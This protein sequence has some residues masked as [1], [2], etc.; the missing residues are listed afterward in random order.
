MQNA[1]WAPV[2]DNMS[3]S[4]LNGMFINRVQAQISGL[5]I[6]PLDSDQHEVRKRLTDLLEKAPSL[7]AQ[8]LF[9]S[10]DGRKNYNHDLPVVSFSYAH[11]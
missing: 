5:K 3:T 4:D 8:R 11:T 9:V 7:A 10:R 6:G 2:V 1:P